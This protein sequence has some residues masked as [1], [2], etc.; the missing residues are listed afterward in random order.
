M[1]D[2]VTPPVDPP[3][4]T[5][6]EP[7]FKVIETDAMTGSKRYLDNMSTDCW[8]GTFTRERAEATVKWRE[9][10]ITRRYS[11]KIVPVEPHMTDNDAAVRRHAERHGHWPVTDCG[12][13]DCREAAGRLAREELNRQFAERDEKGGGA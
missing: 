8:T 2:P 13:V 5:D 4:A 1:A 11:Y 9:E 6:A 12:D 7:Q 3:P 10:N